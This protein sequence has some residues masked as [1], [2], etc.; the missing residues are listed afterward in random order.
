MKY[1]PENITSLKKNQVIVIG[2]NLRGA[3]GAG[4]AKFANLKFGL[5]YGVGEGLSGQTY[6]LPT[7]DLY[8]ETLPLDEIQGYIVCFISF[9]GQNPNLEFLVTKVGCGLAGLEIEEVAELFSCLTIPSNVIL[10]RE[11][12]EYRWNKNEGTETFDF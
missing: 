8:I 11:F 4:A 1:T 6:A 5:K 2:S 9:A 3:H 7:K 12:W 10:P